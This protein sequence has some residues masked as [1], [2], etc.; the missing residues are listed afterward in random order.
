MLMYDI[1]LY[2]LS[3]SRNLLEVFLPQNIY[4]FALYMPAEWLVS[5]MCL[6]FIDF[7]F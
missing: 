4:P 1:I 3:S 2:I 7:R 6:L 5:L